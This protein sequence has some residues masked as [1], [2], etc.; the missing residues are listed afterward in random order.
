MAAIGYFEKQRDISKAIGY[1]HGLGSAENN[2]AI[3]MTK[4][5]GGADISVDEKLR[6]DQKF[7]KLSVKQYG[8]DSIATIGAGMNLAVALKNAHHGLEAERL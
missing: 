8:Q 2:L 1:H 4:C 5:E 6:Q 3:A 7:Y